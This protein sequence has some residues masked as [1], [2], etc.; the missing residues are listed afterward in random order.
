MKKA[1][2]TMTALAL[3]A[4]NAPQSDAHDRGWATA[5]KVMAGVGAGLLLARALEP[6][7][8]YVA[9]RSRDCTATRT[10]PGTAATRT[11]PTAGANRHLRATRNCSAAGGG[12]TRARCL[13]T[14]LRCS[15]LCPA[16]LPSA[17][18]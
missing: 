4:A 2:I 1:L 15:R 6:Q 13:S 11:G 16:G 7:P 8:V 3:L 18:D 9:P 14:R 12:S 17:G 10:R 5:G